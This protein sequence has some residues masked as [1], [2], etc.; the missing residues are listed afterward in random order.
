MSL[1][2][3]LENEHKIYVDVT[4]EHHADGRIIP[5]AFTWEDGTRYKINKV[6][7]MRLAAS[8]KAGGTGLRYTVKVGATQTYMWLEEDKDVLRWF[9]E[10]K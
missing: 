7:D 8:L 1:N 4:V 10:K 3:L 9:M 6:L 5:L 2:E